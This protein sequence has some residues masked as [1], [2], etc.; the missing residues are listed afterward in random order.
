[1]CDT[2]E[3]SIAFHLKNKQAV[4]QK[5][6]QAGFHNFVKTALS[7]WTLI[8]DTSPVP[9]DLTPGR[10]KTARSAIPKGDLE[11]IRGQQQK[12]KL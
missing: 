7:N 5:D 11:K 8:A 2:E 1:M 4:N 3:L 12:T 6:D 10:P 9:I